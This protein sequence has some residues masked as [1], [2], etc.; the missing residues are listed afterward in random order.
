MLEMVSCWYKQ[1]FSDPHAVS[2]AAILVFGFIIIYFFGNLIAPL[3]V[4]MVLAYLLEWPVVNL[5]RL[6]ISRTLSVVLVILIFTSLMLMAVFGLV[7]TIWQQVGNFT[8][9]VPN[10]YIGLQNFVS[11]VPKRYPELA[12]LQI[13]ELLIANIKNQVIA[14][15]ESI[16]KGSV[17]SLLSI[18]TLVVYLVLVPILVFF[19]LKDKQE[20]ISIVTVVLPKNRKLA[21]KVW[22][23]MNDQISNYI[24]GKVLEILIVGGISYVAL[25]VLGLRYAVLLSVAIGFSVLVPYIGAAVVTVPVAIIG[26]F[27][28]GLTPQFYWLMLIYSSIQTLDGNILVPVL[29][30]EA[31][32]LHPVAI[33]SSV[34]V[35][36]G[37][38]GFWG[39]FFAIPLAT[40]VKAVWNVLSNHDEDVSA[41]E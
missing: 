17:A 13:V 37:F 16:L 32:N 41:E 31:V 5:S 26:L 14:V 27:Q 33:I 22:Y 24:R 7:P 10:M 18:A 28:W 2:L 11:I 15:G 35:F 20:M 23:E 9:D 19:L 30:S 21:N 1:R 34:L 25:A 8:N 40:L 3:L 12:N 39:V 6:G 4:A 38:W 36:G 29:F